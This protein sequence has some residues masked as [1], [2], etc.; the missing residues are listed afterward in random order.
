MA[1]KEWR[2]IIGIRDERKCRIDNAECDGRLEVH[3]I[4]GWAE[5]PELRYEVNNGITLC[6][7]H[8][9]RKRSEEKLLIPFFQT[10]LAK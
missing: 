2:R 10:I 8:H 9:P 6:A 5:Y 7:K 4:L 1:Y 3:H